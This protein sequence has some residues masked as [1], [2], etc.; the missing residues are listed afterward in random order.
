MAKTIDEQLLDLLE[1]KVAAIATSGGYQTDMAADRVHFP[2]VGELE[3]SADELEDGPQITI[4]RA[5]K[6]V[7]THI[8]GAHEITL[9]VDIR[10]TAAS[11]DELT[12]VMGDLVKLA[13]ANAL[14]NNGSI[15]LAAKTWWE[16]DDAQDNEVDEAA[17]VGQMLLCV[18]QYADATNPTAVKAI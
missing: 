8:R 11:R 13:K 4:R 6:A 15:N 18:K 14:W 17:L 7:R 1:T 10:I 2:C 9:K 3:F 16:E 5:S 12:A